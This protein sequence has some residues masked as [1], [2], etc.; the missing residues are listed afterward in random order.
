M[1]TFLEASTA[2]V[3]LPNSRIIDYSD[4]DNI[5]MFQSSAFATRSPTKVAIINCALRHDFLALFHI[6]VD[7]HE[8]SAP[9]RVALDKTPF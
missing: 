8:I 4:I 9:G 5:D 2:L 6:V 7:M 3:S 1:W